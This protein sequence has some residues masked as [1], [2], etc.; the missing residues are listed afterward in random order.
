MKF[1]AQV[2]RAYGH[3]QARDAVAVP[4]G[5]CSALSRLAR[6]MPRGSKIGQKGR[7]RLSPCFSPQSFQI[8]RMASPENHPSYAVPKD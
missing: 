4:A 3:K 7:S 2:S 8:R 6:E 1:R 5:N